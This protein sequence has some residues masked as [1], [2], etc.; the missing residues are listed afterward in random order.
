M[1]QHQ[2]PTDVLLTAFS[3]TEEKHL[4]IYLAA[5]Q[6]DTCLSIKGYPAF[7]FT[8]GFVLLFPNHTRPLPRCSEDTQ[9]SSPPFC[10]PC[11]GTGVRRKGRDEKKGSPCGKEWSMVIKAQGTEENQQ[12]LLCPGLL[13]LAHSIKV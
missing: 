4:M 10:R 9:V 13:P 1:S 8:H 5:H 7:L 3:R 6:Q 12:L 2:Q 11:G